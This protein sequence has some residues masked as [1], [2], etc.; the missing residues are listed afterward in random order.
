MVPYILIELIYFRG[1]PDAMEGIAR[2]DVFGIDKLDN[3]SLGGMLPGLMGIIHGSSGSGKTTLASHYLFHGASRG[4][5]VCLITSEPTDSV[6]RK[7]ARFRSYDSSWV[8][9][10]YISIFHIENLFD[11]VGI[12][13]DRLD[14]T[15]LDI[16]SGLITKIVGSMDIKRVVLDP[17]LFLMEAIED[18]AHS[19]FFRDIKS[20]LVQLSS[21]CMVVVDTGIAG[22]VSPFR[23]GNPEV[24]DIVISCGREEDRSVRTKTLCIERWK[25]SAHSNMK[26]VIDITDD[27][28]MI[29]PRIGHREER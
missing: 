25:D 8:R 18:T 10:G 20:E 29:V 21:S 11:L 17:G 19:T 15:E 3:I 28:V 2:D 22:S 24:F 4:Q 26:Y 27:G 9:D 7:F 13:I 5:N 6:M 1:L 23:T 16:A 14:R 12:E